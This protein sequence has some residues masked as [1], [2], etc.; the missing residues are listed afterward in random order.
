M[1]NDTLKNKE[2]PIQLLLIED[3]HGDALLVQRAFE[4]INLENHI[5]IATTGEEALR[6]LHHSKNYGKI[7]IPDIILLD[8][9]LPGIKGLEVLKILK[10]DE[11]LRRIPVII[12]SSSCAQYD[13]INCYNNY[14]NC[15][16]KKASNL[17]ELYE[18][19]KRIEQFWFK[20][21]ILPDE[22]TL[23]YHA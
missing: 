22:E 5:T 20:Q 2:R 7:K 17:D 12:L 18:L 13:V 16:V 10:H 3:N 23:K 9:N 8:L 4:R 21:V 15:Y 6:L 11:R 1:S 14:A 19:A